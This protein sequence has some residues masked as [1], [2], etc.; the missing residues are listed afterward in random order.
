LIWWQARADR[1]NGTWIKHT[2]DANVVDT[3]EIAIADMNKDGNL[4]I[5]VSEQDQSLRYAG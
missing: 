5:V 2:I 1:R 3:Q 4:D